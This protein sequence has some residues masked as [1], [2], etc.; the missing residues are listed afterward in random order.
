MARLRVTGSTLVMCTKIGGPLCFI[1]AIRLLAYRIRG[2][3][4]E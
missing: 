1:V 2:L 3:F 4:H